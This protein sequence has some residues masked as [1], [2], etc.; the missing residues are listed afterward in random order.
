M[1]VIWMAGMM[2]PA[3]DFRRVLPNF[4]FLYQVLL[5]CNLTFLACKS[6]V[7]HGRQFHFVIGQL[8]L[9]V[10]LYSTPFPL[11]KEIIILK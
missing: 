11:N 10:F 9:P 5:F 6:S 3:V 1:K 2:V 4:D 8:C 7:A